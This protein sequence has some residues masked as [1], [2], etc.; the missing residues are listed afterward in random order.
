MLRLTISNF[1]NFDLNGIVIFWL[2]MIG[3][4]T[5]IHI[6]YINVKFLHLWILSIRIWLLYYLVNLVALRI[7]VRRFNCNI[8]IRFWIFYFHSCFGW[9]DFHKQQNDFTKLIKK[10]RLLSKDLLKFSRTDFYRTWFISIISSK[11]IN[12]MPFHPQES[13]CIGWKLPPE[14]PNG[15]FLS[16]YVIYEVIQVIETNLFDI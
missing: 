3:A 9:S 7:K 5:N 1:L 2:K 11:I 13:A 10:M 15:W 6:A 16:F 8:L 12:T 4:F 14:A